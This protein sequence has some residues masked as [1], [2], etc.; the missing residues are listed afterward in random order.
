MLHDSDRNYKYRLALEHTIQRLKKQNPEKPVHVLDI[1][2]GTGLLSMMAVKAGAHLVTACESFRPMAKCAQRILHNNGLSEKINV[3]P[4]RSTD[5]VVGVDM[6]RKADVLV[7]ELFDTELIGEGALETYRHAAENLITA[8][9]S[10]IPCAANIYVQVV[11]SPFL[12]SHHRLLPFQYDNG[13]KVIDLREFQCAEMESCSG[14]ASVF[15]IQV[16]ELQL[17]NDKFAPCER[18]IRCLLKSPQLVKRFEFGPPADQIKLNDFITLECTPST[19]GKAHAFITWWSLQMEPTNSTPSITIAPTWTNDPDCA[20]RD[21]WMQAVYF[22]KTE[23]SLVKNESF[24]LKYSHDSLSMQFDLSLKYNSVNDQKAILNDDDKKFLDPLSCTCDLHR[25]WP[26]TRI[27]ELNSSDYKTLSTKI[28]DSVRTIAKDSNSSLKVLVVSDCTY[29]PC[30]IKKSLDE[31]M[32]QSLI[33]HLDTSPSSCLLLDRIYKSCNTSSRSTIEN[34]QSIE[35][36]LCKITDNKCTNHQ[37]SNT[38]LILVGEPYI[39][40]AILPWDSL[41]FWYAFRSL[42]SHDLAC[43]SLHSFGPTRLRVYA[44]LV[45]FENLWRI[46][47]PVG[48]SCESFDLRQFDELVL[49]ASAKSDELIEPHPL[50]EYPGTARSNHCVIFDMILQNNPD[51]DG[52]FQ[53]ADPENLIQC[54]KNTLTASSNSVNGIAFWCEWLYS[55]PVAQKPHSN[56]KWWY[57]PAGPSKTIKPNETII[58]KSHGSHQGVFLFPSEWKTKISTSDDSF[59]ISVCMDF[60]ISTGVISPCINITH[61]FPV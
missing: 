19:S 49:N 4:K 32:L 53:Y 48:F 7:A 13:D 25:V 9:A 42:L 60:D 58:W 35:H 14:L 41:Y 44:V 61:G 59:Q 27:S 10:L 20:W 22:P 57:S 8:D 18:G 26:R 30:L 52:N 15:D 45:D 6:P 51:L 11:E 31:Y 24:T 46:R 56:E 21:H 16:S 54:Y 33:I 5:L 37:P 29:L 50:W 38:T 28:L 36:V 40:A 23:Y 2:T 43:S 47:S 1:G 34:C 17:E 3:I 55:T 39:T 12:W